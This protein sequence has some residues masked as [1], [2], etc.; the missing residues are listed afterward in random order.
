MVP[1]LRF[2]LNEDVRI[3]AAQSLPELLTSASQAAGVVA[4][5]PMEK[6]ASMVEFI[7]DPLLDAIGR[8]RNMGT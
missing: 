8:V 2:Y 4:E 1:L 6:L 5:M 3:A 7:M